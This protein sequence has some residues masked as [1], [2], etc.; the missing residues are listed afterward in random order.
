MQTHCFLVEEHH[1]Q[2]CDDCIVPLT[3]KHILT[4]CLNFYNERLTYFNNINLAMK[5]M[6]IDTDACFN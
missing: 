1:L 2:F 5:F 6:L 3:I 4:V